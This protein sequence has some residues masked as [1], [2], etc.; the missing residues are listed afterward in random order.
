MSKEMPY[1]AIWTRS[2][3]GQLSADYESITFPG[4]TFI[5]LH[6]RRTP[7]CSY[8]RCA[9]CAKALKFRIK[10]NATKLTIPIVRASLEDGF[11]D[12]PD[13]PFHR[14]F[15]IDEQEVD[16]TTF[17]AKARYIY[18]KVKLELMDMPMTPQ[19]AWLQM[20]A[21]VIAN[22]PDIVTQN[23]IILR[24]PKDKSAKRSFARRSSIGRKNLAEEIA[25]FGSFEPENVNDDLSF[26]LDVDFSEIY[27]LSQNNPLNVP[28]ELLKPI[29]ARPTWLSKS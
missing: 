24:L 10:R 21:E 13:N 16:T 8:F 29:Y 7:Y 3:R 11:L 17:A 27:D 19:Q 28:L 23:E 15:C 1:P 14:H 2:Q 4:N 26:P 5:F 25:N 18:N 6:K 9:H 22:F 12:D 20:K